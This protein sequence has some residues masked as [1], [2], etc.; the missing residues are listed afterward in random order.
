MFHIYLQ[1]RQV[2]NPK[3]QLACV[4]MPITLLSADPLEHN[5]T[6]PMPGDAGRLEIPASCHLDAWSNSVG[7]FLCRSSSEAKEEGVATLRAVRWVVLVV[8]VQDVLLSLEA[9]P[10]VQQHGCVAGRHMQRDVL[11]HAC[12]KGRGH[13]SEVRQSLPKDLKAKKCFNWF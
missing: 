10:L 8:K 13:N 7:S 12:L 6:K 5:K 2:P 11:P 3:I 9:E 1:L 4:L